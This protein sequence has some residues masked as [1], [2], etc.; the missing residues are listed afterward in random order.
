MCFIRAGRQV[1]CPRE[2]AQ[3][4]RLAARVHRPDVPHHGA[5]ARVENPGRGRPGC[6]FVVLPVR[7]VAGAQPVGPRLGSDR[8]D[9]QV[10]GCSEHEDAHPVLPGRQVLDVYE[11]RLCEKEQQGETHG[12]HTVHPLER[13][14]LIVPAH[15]RDLEL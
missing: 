12:C 9:L 14:L 5:R 11:L 8:G 10:L 3:P 6:L 4:V 13:F 1:D 2:P 7:V 15:P